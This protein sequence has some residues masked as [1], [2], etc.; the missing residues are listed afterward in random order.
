M[1]SLDWMAGPRLVWVM[2]QN[3]VFVF[4]FCFLMKLNKQA[5][6]CLVISRAEFF[7]AFLIEYFFL[8]IFWGIGCHCLELC[9]LIIIVIISTV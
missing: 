5:K 1:A 7:F 6:Q 4:I 3:L 9:V 2:W 8:S